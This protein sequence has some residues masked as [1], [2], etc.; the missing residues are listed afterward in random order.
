M[1]TSSRTRYPSDVS[2]NEWAFAAPDLTLMR[3]DA[4]QRQHPLRELFNGLPPWEAV[5]QQTRR[6]LAADVFGT[7]IADLRVLLRLGRDRTAQPTAVILDSR[8]LQSTPESGGR[9]SW[10]GAKKRKGSTV[11]LAVDTLGHLLALHVT[12]A[13]DQAREQVGALAAAVQAETGRDRRDGD[14]SLGRRGVDPPGHDRHHGS[15]TSAYVRSVST[16]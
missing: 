16:L 4:P 1:G 6:W 3:E 5:S 9:T 10:D 13:R 11:H 8:T 12:S 15:P 2:D 14:A 7:L